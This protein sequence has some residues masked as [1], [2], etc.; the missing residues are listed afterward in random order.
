ML[1]ETVGDAQ[2]G[3]ET[4]AKAFAQAL[5]ARRRTVGW[6][7]EQMAQHVEAEAGRPVD[8]AI[9]TALESGTVAEQDRKL[10][11]AVASSYEVDLA[12]LGRVR[13]P[14]EIDGNAFVVGDVRREW[15]SDDIDDVLGAFLAIIRQLRSDTEAEVSRFRRID[16]DVVG[17]HLNADPAL[18]IRRLGELL[19]TTEAR[20]SAMASIYLAGADVIPT[21][22]DQ[23]SQAQSSRLAQLL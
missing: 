21:G 11:A 10:I 7:L 4:F 23:H 1:T 20:Q 13:T 19:G 15:S 16:I 8:P 6:T 14:I 5:S 12:D 22:T 3:S 9:L 2:T 17:A 18:V